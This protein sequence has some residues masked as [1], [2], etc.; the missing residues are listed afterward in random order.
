[1]CRALDEPR[2]RALR[3][4][5]CWLLEL[6]RR[7]R[8]RSVLPLPPFFTMRSAPLS[9]RRLVLAQQVFQH[10]SLERRRQPDPTL[11]RVR[12][13][14]SSSDTPYR[15][16]GTPKPQQGAI[17][18]QETNAREP[19]YCSNDVLYACTSTWKIGDKLRSSS[20]SAAREAPRRAASETAAGRRRGVSK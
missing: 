6:V 18:F 17:D 10:L 13:V 3:A 8:C 1:M 14:C 15:P 16:A 12:A 11:L 9:D 7:A 20:S 19:E 2:Q 4:A 5:L